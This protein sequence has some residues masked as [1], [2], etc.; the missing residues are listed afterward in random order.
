MAWLKAL[1]PRWWRPRNPPLVQNLDADG[2]RAVSLPTP[3]FTS[4]CRGSPAID[5]P[6]E[7][8]MRCGT[9]RSDPGPSARREGERPMLGPRPCFRRGIPALVILLGLVRCGGA[10]P[11]PQQVDLFV[12]GEGGYHTYRIPALAVMPGGTVVALAEGRK[13]SSSDSGDID[14]VMRRSTDHGRTWSD[15]RL[16]YEEGGAAPIDDRQSHARRRSRDGHAAPAVLAKQPT[17]VR[18]DQP[19][20]RG[21]VLRPEGN[22]FRG[23]GV[24]LRLDPAGPR[25][26]RRSATARPAGCWPRSGSMRRS[27]IRPRI[28]SARS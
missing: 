9:Q 21:D 18:D 17:A 1:T 8:S 3:C 6:S 19:R 23:Q 14:L 2:R 12:S 15:M 28:A 24:R 7:S 25:A 5:A 13:T 22:H 10:A 26:D 20:R 11:D 4:P 27:A 16:V